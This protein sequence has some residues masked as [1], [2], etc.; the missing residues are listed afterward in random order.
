[1]PRVVDLDQ[2]AVAG[3]PDL[4]M[5][6]DSE[7]SEVVNF[8]VDGF[9]EQ[10]LAEA[11]SASDAAIQ[12]AVDAAIDD[13]QPLDSD[14][15]AIAALTPS[16][17]D[18]LQRKSGAWTN[19]TPAQVKTDLVLTKTDV[20]LSNVDNTSDANK[21]VSTAQSTAISTAQSTAI[22]TSASYADAEIAELTGYVKAGSIL[23]VS[24]NQSANLQGLANYVT[25]GTGDSTTIKT[26]IEAANGL[27]TIL[28]GAFTLG[29]SVTITNFAVD[30]DA[31]K[32]T[33]TITSGVT[34]PFTFTG[35]RTQLG[36]SSVVT[37]DAAVGAKT[38]SVDTAVATGTTVNDWQLVKTLTSIGVTE[39]SV[40]AAEWNQVYS[41]TSNTITYKLPFRFAHTISPATTIFKYT[42]VPY[43]N[44][45]G[46]IVNGPGV[47]GVAHEMFMEVQYYDVV[48]VQS[49]ILNSMNSFAIGIQFDSSRVVHTRNITINNVEDAVGSTG[50]YSAR[51][52]YGIRYYGCWQILE[53]NCEYTECRHGNDF[54]AENDR[55]VCVQGQVINSIAMHCWSSGLGNHS[56]G[57]NILFDHC[58]AINCGGGYVIR[59]SN[60]TLRNV[61]VRAVHQEVGPYSAT[62]AYRYPY[63]VSGVNR[64]GIGF[65]MEGCEYDATGS[66]I[67]TG[68]EVVRIQGTLS[69]YKI[70]L[71]RINGTLNTHIVNIQ[72]DDIG[73]GIIELDQITAPGS[74]NGQVIR[75][76]S[77][78][79]NPTTFGT[80]TI[81]GGELENQDG[82][83]VRIKA[84]TSGTN[85]CVFVSG[86][87]ATS[88]GAN[89]GNGTVVEYVGGGTTTISEV[90]RNR[91]RAS[92]AANV[93]TVT[94][95]TVTANLK[96]YNIL[97]TNAYDA[98]D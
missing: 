76:V 25:T 16:N 7:T 49:L 89:V 71:A 24:N 32:A 42:L 31:T 37:A 3:N 80:M 19:R 29:S 34:K 28:V 36:D 47:V 93:V 45:T 65:K 14:L 27:K 39:T 35:T 96:N 57:D 67:S 33:F 97:T 23:V 72:S 8:S 51:T 22:S 52:G 12:A 30:V 73:D 1:M 6:V 58:E 60:T 95:S 85:T 92:S 46:G 69:N 40:Y 59:A 61:K 2:I 41:K 26:A 78:A 68:T 54:N 21:P 70:H 64:G 10:V 98:V 48:D 38:L 63:W 83:I 74:Y 90:F 79:T 94:S 43:F 50:F 15:T 17:D 13:L 62:E 11:D 84:P 66:S 18:V 91:T 82:A 20:G 5:G 53:E 81:K 77:A 56:G 9:K 87:H 88:S 86:F 55:G 75:V 44:W 4:F